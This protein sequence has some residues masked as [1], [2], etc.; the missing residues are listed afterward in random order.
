MR[1]RHDSNPSGLA[2][3]IALVSLVLPWAGIGLA[4]AGGLMIARGTAG[5][6]QLLGCG[7]AA[8]VLDIVIDVIWA[9]PS[10]SRSDEPA[11]NRRALQLEGRT[12]DVVEAI[13]D[14][15]GKVRIG[16]SVWVA[17]GLDAPEGAMV[18]VT[19]SRG[20]ALIVENVAKDTPDAPV[21]D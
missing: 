11:L 19:G 9:H 20:T 15:R 13:R 17:E 1:R 3:T 12:C 2:W 6:W 21:A 14:G 10:V 18:R 8:L 16:D 7:L 4:L 5:G